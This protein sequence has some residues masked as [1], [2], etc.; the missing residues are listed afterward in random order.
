MLPLPTEATIENTNTSTYWHHPTYHWRPRTIQAHWIHAPR[1]TIVNTDRQIGSG[2]VRMGRGHW[3]LKN[4]SFLEFIFI[5]ESPLFSQQYNVRDVE[6]SK[7]DTAWQQPCR[8]KLQWKFTA[9]AADVSDPFLFEIF[10]SPLRRLY[11]LWSVLLMKRSFWSV[12]VFV[13][14]SIVASVGKW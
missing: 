1:H 9:I 11:R 3:R 4:S 12:Q 7:L 2:T 14:F 8:F 10:V 13:F 6:N 5:L